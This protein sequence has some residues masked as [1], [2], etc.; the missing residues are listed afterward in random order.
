[1]RVDKL[2]FIPALL[3]FAGCG[4]R[5][6]TVPRIEAAKPGGSQPRAN[7]VIAFV[8][9]KRGG[10][11]D[12]LLVTNADGSNKTVVYA[13]PHI[14]R[15]SWS[16]DGHSIVFRRDGT[17]A[18]LWIVDVVIGADGKP[19]GTNDHKLTSQCGASFSSP[20]IGC[21]PAWS[22]TR[23]EI[24]FT[25]PLT[26]DP[27]TNQ[28]KTNLWL[29]TADGGTATRLYTATVGSYGNLHSP[30]WSPDGDRIAV[31][32]GFGTITILGDL[33]TATPSVHTILNFAASQLVIT[34]QDWAH[35]TTNADILAFSAFPNFGGT[36]TVYQLSV[37][38]GSF[39]K[40]IE[41]DAPTWSPNDAN[42]AFIQGSR[43]ALVSFILPT[44]PSTTL[45][46]DALDPDWARRK[47]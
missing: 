2:A 4:E 29:I 28:Y 34:D 40:V 45:A 1:M 6:P 37:S 26:P 3:L 47:P 23:S 39:L 8:N 36:R 25:E 27:G 43:E 9:L 42:L 12:Q 18:E 32:E 11:T 21:E 44:G 13:A 38:S 5:Q 14:L 35:T 20:Y 19:Q 41:G 46:V 15:P 30:T 16:P 17:T 31:V 7:P 24:A 10:G 33:H 22:P